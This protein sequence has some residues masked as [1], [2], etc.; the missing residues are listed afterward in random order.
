MRY[1]EK[2][3]SERWEVEW[4]LPGAGEGR[5]ELFNE[6]RVSAGKKKKFWR[7]MVVMVVP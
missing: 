7:W 3:N 5:I 1:L 6:Y 4:W 2:S